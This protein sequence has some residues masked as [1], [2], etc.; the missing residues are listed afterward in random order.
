MVKKP[1]KLESRDYLISNFIQFNDGRKHFV[2]G[3]AL[4]Y[5]KNKTIFNN[6]DY[7]N[8]IYY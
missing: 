5:M 6:K 1:I 4:I 8:L 7:C 2:E 3:T